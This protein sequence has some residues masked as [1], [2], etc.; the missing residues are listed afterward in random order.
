MVRAPLLPSADGI[1]D[2][3]RL[4]NLRK[5]NKITAILH[6]G[7]P[8]R[9]WDKDLGPDAPHLLALDR[10]DDASPADLT[11]RPGGAL[12]DADFDVSADGRFVV[13]SWQRP[14]P[15]A[16]QH[17]VLVRIDLASGDAHRHRRRAGGRPVEP[18]HLAGRVGGGVH[19]RVVLHAG[20]RTA[21]QPGLLAVRRRAVPSSRADWDRWPVSVTWSRDG[22]ALL[23]AADDGGRC[24][25]FR[26]G[27]GDGE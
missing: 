9:H 15:D 21:N 24:P 10:A 16:S 2:D 25:V 5:D 13:T 6:T 20:A 3:R 12:R 27:I 11:P 7:Y 1:D 14:A 17:S 4:R 8:I 19:P 23:V 18:G 26:I 22:D